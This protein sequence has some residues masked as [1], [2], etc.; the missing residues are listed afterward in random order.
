MKIFMDIGTHGSFEK[1]I[2]Q[3][4]ETKGEVEFVSTVQEADG[5]LVSEPESVGVYLDRTNK[6]VA[7]LLWWKQKPSTVPQ[8]DRFKIFD[9]FNKGCLPGLVEAIVFLRGD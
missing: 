3:V 2:K 5:I 7:Q 9:A 8:S 1:V 6:R 4:F